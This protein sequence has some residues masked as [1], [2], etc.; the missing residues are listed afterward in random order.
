[1]IDLTT[2]SPWETITLTT[3][4]RDRGIFTQLLS[5]ARELALAKQEG[6]TVIYTSWGPEWRP[7][8]LPR[9]RRLLES[10]I[11]DDGV[12]ERVV[13]DVR[14][15][16]GNGKWYNERGIYIHNLVLSF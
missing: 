6:K 11:L 14:E 1:M 13:K 7:F 12:M 4:S 16:I 9:R 5:E 3:L 10:V 8:G 2:G 15:F